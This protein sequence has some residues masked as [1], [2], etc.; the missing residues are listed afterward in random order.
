MIENQKKFSKAID[1]EYTLSESTAKKK[2]VFGVAP[3]KRPKLDDYLNK[4]YAFVRSVQYEKFLKTLGASEEV[5]KEAVKMKPTVKLT[6]KK[7]EYKLTTSYP[8]FSVETIKF[9][10]GKKI[11]RKIQ[12]ESE[13]ESVFEIYENYLFEKQNLPGLKVAIKRKFTEHNLQI[14]I[15]A[16]GV[17]CHRYYK[18]IESKHSIETE[19][20]RR[21]SLVFPVDDPPKV[22]SPLVESVIQYFEN[23][24]S[25]SE[26]EDL[27]Y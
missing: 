2:S 22:A 14:T 19:T 10:N 7:G 24:E 18:P 9:K 12:D 26:S 20:S 1:V 6:K 3:F 5:V 17:R 13:I 16:N 4:T 8:D 27:C 21:R 15:E 11:Q 25:G 23:S